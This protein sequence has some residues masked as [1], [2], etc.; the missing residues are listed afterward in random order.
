V[1][2]NIFYLISPKKI[3]MSKNE[4]MEI[5][6]DFIIINMTCDISRLDVYRNENLR[7]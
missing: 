6:K 1:F 5:E 3:K 2:D 7:K 4:H